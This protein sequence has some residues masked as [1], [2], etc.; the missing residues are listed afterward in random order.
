[1]ENNENEK[2]STS[3]DE[4]MQSQGGL[5]NSEVKQENSFENEVP[6]K[7]K[8]R[9]IFQK[10]FSGIIISLSLVVFAFLINFKMTYS[11]NIVEGWSMLPTLNSTT[12][13]DEEKG[14]KVY[15]NTKAEIKQQDIV[16]IFSNELKENIIKRCIAVGGQTVN[17]VGVGPTAYIF[18]ERVND[19]PVDVPKYQRYYVEVDGKEINEPYINK[20]GDQTVMEKEF[21]RFYL[22]KYK[23]GMRGEDLQKA[24]TIQQDEIFALGDNRE[25]SADSS[26]VGPF[27]KTEIV[28]RV[29]HIIYK[30]TSFVK[31]CLQ[32]ISFIFIIKK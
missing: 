23:Q 6:Q 4:T 13:S 8:K 15:I 25:N 18:P 16:V 21:I 10:V 14:D 3:L 26:S 20:A 5:V 7:K 1:M 28:G 30:G 24:I 19:V 9:R 27:N 31:E 29:D 22:W 11:V 17:I 2:S 32:K 12:L